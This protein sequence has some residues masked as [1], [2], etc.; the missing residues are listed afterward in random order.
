[1]TRD[2]LG[3]M[4]ADLQ[5]CFSGPFAWMDAPDAPSVFHAIPAQTPGIYL[6]TVNRGDGHLV[7][8]VGESGRCICTRLAE[9]YMEH[10]AGRYSLHDP[11]RYRLGEKHE[12]WPGHYGK[13]GRD[14][15]DCVRA[16]IQLAAQITEL[17]RQVRFFVAPIECE[18]RIRR[19]LEAAIVDALF[20]VPGVVG[21]FQDRGVRYQ[22]RRSG[23]T[24]IKASLNTPDGQVVLGLPTMIEA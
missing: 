1:M 4:H 8:Y 14:L 5:V 20:A 15:G 17:A 23:E 21:T 11:V 7:A 3:G 10:A 22:R 24:V 19:R 6:W 16:S 13:D 18:T 2:P 12:I 9:H